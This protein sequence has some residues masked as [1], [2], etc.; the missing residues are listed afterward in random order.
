MFFKFLQIYGKVCVLPSQNHAF[1]RD[2]IELFL[3]LSKDSE[4]RS[5]YYSLD[6]LMKPTHEAP[7]KSNIPASTSI[8]FRGLLVLRK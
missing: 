1:E 2:N 7:V 6:S 8:L 4:K 3:I 5:A